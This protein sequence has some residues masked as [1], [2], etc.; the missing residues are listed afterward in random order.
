[1]NFTWFALLLFLM[2]PLSNLKMN[3]WLT[4]VAFAIFSTEER[5]SIGMHFSFSFSFFRE[6]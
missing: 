5:Y 4:P 1:M 2:W 6:L 3:T